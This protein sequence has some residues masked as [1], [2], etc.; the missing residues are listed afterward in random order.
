MSIGRPLEVAVSSG[1]PFFTLEPDPDL[2]RHEVWG[3]DPDDDGGSATRGAGATRAPRRLT[4]WHGFEGGRRWRLTK[5]GVAIQGGDVPRTDGEPVTTTRIWKSFAAEINDASARFGVPCALVIATI[6]TEST[7]NP[8]ALRLEPGF[9]SDKATPEKVSPGLM[10]T[11]ISTAQ[12][13]L[14][15]PTIDRAKLFTPH[16]SILA[17]TAFI[18]GQ[19]ASTRLDPPKVAAA[20]NAGSVRF[21]DAAG[22][23]WRMRCFPPGT[24]AHVTRFVEWFNDAVSVLKTTPPAPT[25]GYETLLV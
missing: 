11:L 13:T 5:R 7:G 8:K 1:D 9:V 20:Y 24:G 16:W 25:V 2:E 22:N 14:R 17:G 4:A 12:A 3:E 15:D 6:A 18:G 10:Q 19:A 23:P 21:E